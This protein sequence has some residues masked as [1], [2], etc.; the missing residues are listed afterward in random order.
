MTEG[1]TRN[2]SISTEDVIA[3]YYP[4]LVLFFVYVDL[5]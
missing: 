5:G 4:W 3:N 2:T 1:L